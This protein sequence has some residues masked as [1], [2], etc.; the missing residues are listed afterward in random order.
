MY[1][2]FGWVPDIPDDRDYFYKA[3]NSS[4]KLPR[5]IDLRKSCFAVE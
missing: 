1:K 2:G 5:T 3:I 4:I